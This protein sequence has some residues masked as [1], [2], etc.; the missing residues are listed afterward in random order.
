[1]SSPGEIENIVEFDPQGKYILQLTE[2]STLDDARQVSAQI[3]EWLKSDLEP[4]LIL[5]GGYRL[6]RR[7]KQ[8]GSGRS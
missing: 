6:V 8:D 4:F 7:D 1:M 2:G 3:A 5:T